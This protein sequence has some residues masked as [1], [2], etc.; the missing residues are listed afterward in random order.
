M[1]NMTASP[2]LSFGVALSLLLGLTGCK[3]MPF[4]KDEPAQ[5]QLIQVP[6][7]SPGG[8]ETVPT[9]SGPPPAIPAEPLAVPTAPAPVAAPQPV[10]VVPATPVPPVVSEKPAIAGTGTENPKPILPAPTETQADTKERPYMS[11]PLIPGL[12]EGEPLFPKPA[13]PTEPTE[14]TEPAGPTEPTEPTEPTKPA[15]TPSVT[16][17]APVV[18]PATPA[19]PTQPVT[20]AVVQGADDDKRYYSADTRQPFSGNAVLYFENGQKKFE[21]GFKD[22]HRHGDGTEWYENGKIKYEGVFN[23]ERL[24]TGKA[25]WYYADSL[26]LKLR[27]EYRD[28]QMVDAVHLSRLT[29]KRP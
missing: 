1:K 6:D 17:I 19:T 25:Y 21:G 28:G 26:A 15:V 16:P 8:T 7:T 4:G 23:G 24:L 22:G 10:P 20:P 3:F 11:P 27:A 29:N 18:T 2:V 14:P 12:K 13:E 9:I 5:A